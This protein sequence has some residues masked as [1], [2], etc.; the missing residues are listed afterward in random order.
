[1]LTGC[2]LPAGLARYALSGEKLQMNWQLFDRW[3]D[4]SSWRFSHP[5]SDS[6]HLKLVF[7][8]GCEMQRCTPVQ[9][10]ACSAMQLTAL[11]AVAL[12]GCMVS[13]LNPPLMHTSLVTHSCLH[14]DAVAR[15]SYYTRRCGKL[16]LSFSLFTGNGDTFGPFDKSA[17]KTRCGLGAALVSSTIP[18][19]LS[20][21]VTKVP[22]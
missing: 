20:S 19:S 7:L 10:C 1:M 8:L 21:S 16:S 22:E 4:V 2:R 9:L 6:L 17:R 3:R 5:I 15:G 12:N 13:A 14:S 18:L 11:I